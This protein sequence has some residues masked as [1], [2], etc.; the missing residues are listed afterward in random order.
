MLE[1]TE[2]PQDYKDLELTSS[3]CQDHPRCL[4]VSINI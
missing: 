4:E 1:N 3:S 2:A